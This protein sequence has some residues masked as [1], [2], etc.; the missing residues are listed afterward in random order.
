MSEQTK[1]CT[2]CGKAKPLS[3]FRTKIRKSG[4][5]PASSCK[6][7]DKAEQR[8][9]WAS[10]K[11]KNKPRSEWSDARVKRHN[12]LKEK[13]RREQGQRPIEEVRAERAAQKAAR[14]KAAEER[15]EAARQQREAARKVP[16]GL[17]D[18]EKFRWRYQ[19]DPEFR[20]RQ[21]QRTIEAKRRVPLWYANQQLGGTS[22]TRYP[23]PLLLA[24][25]MQIRIRYQLKEQGHEEH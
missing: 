1:A 6:E 4:R 23:M 7:C 21:R 10:G 12:E 20:E 8:A 17:T 5:Y 13:Y 14:L 25:Q 16:Q 18:A 3:E 2:K 11:A 15:K 19:N 9:R 24:K 22:D